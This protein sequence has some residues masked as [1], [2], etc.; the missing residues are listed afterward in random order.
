[1][2]L[3]YEDLRIIALV[4]GLAA[5][6]AGVLTYTM[7]RYTRKAQRTQALERDVWQAKTSQDE[8]T[9]NR[10]R[11]V[12]EGGGLDGTEDTQWRQGYLSCANAVLRELDH[13]QE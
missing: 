12:T 11:Q 7:S 8:S 13:E 6:G 3:T 4:S 9:L 2:T 5:L 10:I 1:M